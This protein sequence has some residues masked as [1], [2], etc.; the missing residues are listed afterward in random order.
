MS[1]A[2]RVRRRLLGIASAEV[3]F[4]RRGFPATTAQARGQLEQAG[5]AFLEGYHT[6]L[7]EPC[8]EPLAARL[9]SV[10]SPWRG[11][12]FEG[13]A[14]AL[15][16]LDRLTWRSG[17]WRA[18]LLGPAISHAYLVHVGAGWAV[19]RV[20]WSTWTFAGQLRRL[21]PLLRWLVVDG[22]G[23]HDGYFRWPQTVLEQ[24]VPRRLHGYARRAYD[25]GLGRSLWFVCGAQ[26]DMIEAKISDFSSVRRADLWSGVG[27]ACGYAGGVDREAIEELARRCGALRTQLAQGAVFAAKARQRGDDPAEHTELACRVLCGCEAAEAAA[28]ADEALV[29][30]TPDGRDPLYES[31]RRR[32]GARFAVPGATP[33]DRTAAEA[34]EPRAG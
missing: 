5:R 30:L 7:D 6:A 19:A 25:Q 21:D 1:L 26:P 12:A 13:A 10:E 24:Q 4:V 22:Y 34:G 17:R 32:I 29:D 28:I 15:A 14:M 18:F 9:G 27:L 31:W 8:A 11:F 33:R 16:L 2:G 23:F 20:P 3:T